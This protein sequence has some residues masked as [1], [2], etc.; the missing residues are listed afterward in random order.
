MDSNTRMKNSNV[1]KTLSKMCSKDSYVDTSLK[2]CDFVGFSS[3]GILVVDGNYDLIY[4]SRDGYSCLNIPGG[5]RDGLEE[6][7]M[8]TAMREYKEEGG[9][10][11]IQFKDLKN[12]VLWYAPGKYA[13]FI[14]EKSLLDVDI[15]DITDLHNFSKSMITTY[16]NL[17]K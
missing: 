4:E 10:Y 14:V 13:L 17:S 15:E 8:Q 1:F 7:P 12:K 5:K 6:D 11:S 3:A 16:H 2:P 9:S